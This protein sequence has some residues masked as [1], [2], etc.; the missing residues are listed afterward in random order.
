MASI[1]DIEK[2]LTEL[3]ETVSRQFNLIVT[4][5]ISAIMIT[6]VLWSVPNMPVVELHRNQEL[7]RAEIEKLKGPAAPAPAATPAATPA[8]SAEATPA[9][10]K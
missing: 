2:R 5:I 6:F 3:E 4:G 9:G 1:D 7:L 8:A 10:T